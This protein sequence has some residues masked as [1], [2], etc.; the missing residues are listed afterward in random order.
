MTKR[1]RRRKVD[2]LRDHINTLRQQLA[3]FDEQKVALIQGMHTFDALK[4]MDEFKLTLTM[5]VLANDL[6]WLRGQKDHI[7]AASTFGGA[8]WT[9]RTIL[10]AAIRLCEYSANTKQLLDETIAQ[11]DRLHHQLTNQ[12]ANHDHQLLRLPQSTP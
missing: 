12:G 4:D 6:G 11:H 5:R 1:H 3:N 7:Y 2:F 8:A 10:S 9:M